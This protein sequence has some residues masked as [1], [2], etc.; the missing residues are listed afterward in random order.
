MT[1]R[2]STHLLSSKTGKGFLLGLVAS[3]FLCSGNASAQD[4]IGGS[5]SI[6]G[7]ASKTSSS[8]TNQGNTINLA[9]DFGWYF[10]DNWAFG[11]RPVIGF[12]VSTI[13]ENSQGR[14]LSLGFNPYARYRLLDYNR[15]GLW[16]EA[17]PEIG[18]QREWSRNSGGDWVTDN[19]IFHYDIRLVPVLTYQLNDHISLESRL[20][21]FSLAF[22]G[23][24]MTRDDGS[25]HDT[26]SYG[27]S[28]TTKDVTGTLENIS[29]GFLYKF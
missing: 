2:M 17:S 10:G 29:I 23:Y 26:F 5:V 20:N 27:L 6:Y 19:R 18:F 3:L 1:R 7:L 24:H 12:R 14:I 28:A 21:L 22:M 9:P 13:N 15:F 16:A 25:V 8:E 11:I 4:Y